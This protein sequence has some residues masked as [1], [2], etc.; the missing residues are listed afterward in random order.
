MRVRTDDPKAICK[1]V[2][3]MFPRL[4]YEAQVPKAS[5]TQG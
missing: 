5:P 2:G 1:R 3:R 4:R